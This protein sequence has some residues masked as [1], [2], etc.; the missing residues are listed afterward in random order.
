VGFR[1]A[2]YNAGEMDGVVNLFHQT[3]RNGVRSDT[4]TA[5][6]AS[7][8]AKK[9]LT[10][11]H[12][13]QATKL[14]FA[15]D[16]RQKVL[17]VQVADISS[18]QRSEYTIFADKEVIVSCGAIQS[19]Q[20]L[21]LS[22]IGDKNDLH[23][24]GIECRVELPGVGK[25]MEDHIAN[26]IRFKPAQPGADLG[27]VNATRSE[28][29]LSL[30]QWAVFG[31]GVL[32]SSCYDATLF[33]K[34]E[35]FKKSHPGYGPDIQIGL[36]CAGGDEDIFEKNIGVEPEHNFH[37][38]YYS[39]PDDQD[40]LMV[41]TLLH[42]HSRGSVELASTDPFAPPKI[43]TG[44][45][46]DQ[47]D[48]EALVASYRKCLELGRSSAMQKAG[49]GEAVF[50]REMLARHN[51]DPESYPFLEEYA[52]A[53]ASSLYHPTGTCRMSS[54]VDETL[55]VLGVKG[56]RVADASIMP[57]IVSGNTNAASIVIGEKAA[58]MIKKE[59][60]L[61]DV[62]R[63]KAPRRRPGT[64]ACVAVFTVAAATVIFVRY[65]LYGGPMRWHLER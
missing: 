45:C 48:M 44:F 35:P 34:T 31:T 23:R 47:R 22:G 4:N 46:T 25:D 53:S 28:R 39:Q 51:G 64:L 56:L 24:L 6:I 49:V 15:D 26:W 59:H 65:R 52:R 55:K 1:R 2:D 32:A 41:P 37:K 21:M 38:E 11:I 40:F 7:Q 12:F 42:T 14:L 63:T 9:N 43:I 8:P 60:G 62:V 36:F 18:T 30:I 27:N 50:D 61:R 57:T 5:F 16:D 20:L 58:L 10:V 17:G 19:P 54:V 13:G 29:L 3:V 33:Y